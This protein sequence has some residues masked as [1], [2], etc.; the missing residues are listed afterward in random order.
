VGSQH[1]GRALVNLADRIGR[2]A[3]DR[4]KSFA[5]ITETAAEL[6]SVQ[7]AGIW[8]YDDERTA[9]ECVDLY[10]VDGG[11]H[12]RGLRLDASRYPAYFRALEEARI[13]DADDAAGD[14]RTSEFRKTYLEPTGIG[15]LLDAPIRAR[16]RMI[17]VICHEHVGPPREWTPEETSLAATMADFVALSI[18]SAERARSEFERQKVEARLARAQ[19]MEALGRLA[20][21][22]AHDFNNLLTAVQGS[23]EL[24]QFELDRKQ[25][26]PAFLA[27]ELRN[28]ER[29]AER[30]GRLTRQLSGFSRSEVAAAVRIHPP[31]AL[32]DLRDLIERLVGKGVELVIEGDPDTPWIDMDPGRFEQVVVNLATNAG[33]AM[34]KGGTLSIRSRRDGD[35]CEL[36]VEDT[37]IGI[38]PEVLP[39]IFEPFYSTKQVGVGWG[40]GLAT[41]QGIVEAC[42][43]QVLVRSEPR[44]GTIFRILLPA[45][46]P[47]ER[48]AE[49][50]EA[51]P[52]ADSAQGDETVLLCEDDDRIRGQLGAAL[53]RHGYEVLAAGDGETAVSMA[54]RFGGTIHLLLTDVVMP[55]V[56]GPAL[57]MTLRRLRPGIK[58][59][60]ISGY[61]ADSLTRSGLD[62]QEELFLAK[63]FRPSEAVLRVREVLDSSPG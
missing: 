19:K 53:A 21:G 18:E 11:T 38:A 44:K 24:I 61:S 58:V 41:V 46:P 20:G 6:L 4:G 23:L 13:I 17:G 37:G 36:A 56:G 62:A 14:P 30:A 59:L 43:G 39:L 7:R 54:E 40:L 57:A 29:A 15:A 10:E 16:G 28:I 26:D 47:P 5:A 48:G 45:V 8:L 22:I 35:R 27:Q 52:A 25:L 3:G 50:P 9:I 1:P 49:E 34:A 55:G 63:P 51:E 32:A 33:D 42:G 12:E 31:A 2:H 60:F